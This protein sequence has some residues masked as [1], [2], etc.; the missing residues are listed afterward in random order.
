MGEWRNFTI[1][2]DFGDGDVGENYLALKS[3]LYLNTLV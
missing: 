1:P 3:T 2:I